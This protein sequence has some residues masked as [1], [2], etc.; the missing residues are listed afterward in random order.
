MLDL[1]C[2]SEPFC[3]TRDYEAA[4]EAAGPFRVVRDGRP[5]EAAPEAVARLGVKVSFGGS[6]NL[7]TLPADG[8]RQTCVDGA[9]VVFRSW[10]E[11][12]TCTL[13]AGAVDGRAEPF[14]HQISLAAVSADALARAR[15]E[16]FVSV[17]GGR[18]RLSL[19][20]LGEGDPA[21]P[22]LYTAPV[23]PGDRRLRGPAD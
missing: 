14:L 5:V 1:V 9:C 12:L 22:G 16:V 2:L 21:A 4:S 11:G 10:C 19:A 8:L 20:Q 17:D 7:V 13:Q 15:A 18:R 6:D 3:V 23:R